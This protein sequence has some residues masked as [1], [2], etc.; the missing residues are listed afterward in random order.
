MS[1]KVRVLEIGEI[2]VFFL[3]VCNWVLFF[4]S[5]GKKWDSGK[6]IIILT[7]KLFCGEENYS[8][9]ECCG[10]QNIYIIII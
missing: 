10:N 1:F 7:I 9:I 4:S 2:V 8:G 6:K 3:Y 5:K